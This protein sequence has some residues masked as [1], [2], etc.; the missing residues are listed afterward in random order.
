MG[1]RDVIAV[2]AAT[3]PPA[4][5]DPFE[6]AVFPT[7]QYVGLTQLEAE[8]LGEVE[9]RVV[10]VVRI[11]DEFFALTQDLSPTRVNI[12]IEAGVVVAATSG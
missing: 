1:N 4:T 5:E 6:G 2:A 9:Q 12:E 3:A 8:A 11:D 7:D 10:R